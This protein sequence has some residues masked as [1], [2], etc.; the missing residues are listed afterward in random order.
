MKKDRFGKSKGPLSKAEIEREAQKEL[1]RLSRGAGPR[2]TFTPP[3]GPPTALDEVADSMRGRSAGASQPFRP[4]VPDLGAGPVGMPQFGGVPG[5]RG[6]PPPSLEPDA[7]FYD[8]DEAA[9]DEAANVTEIALRDHAARFGSDPEDLVIRQ[10]PFAAEMMRDQAM[11][12]FF[13]KQETKQHKTSRKASADPVTSVL[14]RLAARK[15]AEEEILAQGDD[16]SGQS[17]LDRI[18]ARREALVAEVDP[19]PPSPLRGGPSRGGQGRGRPRMTTIEEDDED[20]DDSPLAVMRA[21][22]E[23]RRPPRPTP[24]A[25]VVAL[26]GTELGHDDEFDDDQ[27]GPLE[28]DFEFEDDDEA[29]EAIEE[30]DEL[31]EYDELV[32]DDELEAPSTPSFEDVVSRL[33]RV[34]PPKPAPAPATKRGARVP[35]AR[36]AARS[37]R[38]VPKPKAKSAAAK[39]AAA[40]SAAKTSAAKTSAD[41]VGAA[42]VPRARKSAT[43]AAAKP[44]TKAPS[45]RGS[46]KAAPVVRTPRVDTATMAAPKRAT[47]AAPAQTAEVSDAA[48]RKAAAKAKIAAAAKRVQSTR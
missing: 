15:K 23:A 26:P 13:E 7:P 16:G 31:D 24:P 1:E 9:A 39:S 20:D 6:A 22:A 8:D 3:S 10:D 21:R 45:P 40:K 12:Q 34:S 30:S 19:P 43:K 36:P 2:P 18:R 42:K 35:V 48:A 17:V 5:R 29:I 25:R 14:N 33:S 11:R 38:P 37:A 46:A 4:P 41:R 47:E 28:A 44:A 27:D 32:G